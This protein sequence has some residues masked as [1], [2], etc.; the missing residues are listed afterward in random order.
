MFERRLAQGDGDKTL[1]AR[2]AKGV[3]EVHDSYTFTSKKYGPNK[4]YFRSIETWLDGICKRCGPAPRGAP[5]VLG[6]NPAHAQQPTRP[7]SKR[8]WQSVRGH[9]QA[10]GAAGGAA[11]ICGQAGWWRW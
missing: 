8:A 5:R 10:A 1:G 3:V 11:C 6:P 4:Y 2:W 9:Q 7:G